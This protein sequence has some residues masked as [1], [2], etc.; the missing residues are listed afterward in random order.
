MRRARFDVNI[1]VADN[2]VL[3]TVKQRREVIGSRVFE[4]GNVTERWKMW[5]KELKDNE[6]FA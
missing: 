4:G 1:D 3:V 2:G 5:L 6:N